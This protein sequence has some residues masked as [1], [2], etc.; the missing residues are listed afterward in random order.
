[1]VGLPP[2]PAAQHFVHS[3]LGGAVLSRATAMP[4]GDSRVGRVTNFAIALAFMLGPASALVAHAPA[5]KRAGL[6]GEIHASWTRVPLRTWSTR[7]SE[8]AGRPVILDRR[9]DPDRVVTLTAR[10]E[11]LREILARV[12]AEAGAV[13]E[14]LESTVRIVPASLAGKAR[15]AD[16]DRRLRITKASGS[17][18]RS[19]DTDAP[20]AWPVAARPRDL[21]ASLATNAGLEVS[22]I[23][24]I[25]HDHLPAADLP[26]LSVAERFDLV[27]A[28]FD[29]RVSWKLDGTK[30]V[31]RIVAIDAEI[32]PAALADAT[33]PPQKNGRRPTAARPRTATIRD[34]FTLELEAPLDQALSAIGRQLD[35]EVEIDRDSLVARGVALSEIVR[36]DVTKVSREKL[37]DAILHPLGLEWQLEDRKLRVFAPAEGP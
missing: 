23:D 31:G 4:V 37:F 8:L 36:A 30:P 10:G 27:L 22:G 15:T 1:M 18:R 11:P 24:T 29:R 6:D 35:V 33:A 12:A 26:R 20:W 14:E 19:L 7:V 16:A 5:I 13:V 34:E 28:H 25:P 9:L 21:V 32:S 17:A 2:P 3:L